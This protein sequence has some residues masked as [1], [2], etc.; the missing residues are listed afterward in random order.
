VRTQYYDGGS[1]PA[2][3][4][5]TG[6]LSAVVDGLGALGD[7]HRSIPDGAVPRGLGWPCDVAKD[8]DTQLCVDGYCCDDLCD[9]TEPRNKCRA[10]NV[11]GI[12]GRCVVALDGTD[13]RGSCAEEAPSTCGQDGT[14]DGRGQCRKWLSGT[15]CSTPS[16]S[17]GSIS[18]ARA[19]DGQGGCAPAAP[20][21]SC[22]PFDCAN[23]SAC[24]IFCS[25]AV[26]CAS[27]AACT[28]GS[29]GAR[30]L[31]QECSGAADCASGHCA[32]GVCCQTACAGT[33]RACDLPGSVGTCAQVPS[34]LDPH[35]DCAATARE[36]CGADGTCDGAGGCRRWIPGT[37]CG[38]PC[39]GGV[40]GGVGYHQCDGAGSCRC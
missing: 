26:G 24:A 12:E 29:C 39:S 5:G 8:C 4:A 37:A 27:G 3:D 40:D 31:G 1:H 14:C 11:P 16:C 13:P 17:A 2:D 22:G 9:P 20:P 10:C 32:E 15:A 35:D 23:T 21:I 7:L 30:A 6:D 36:S 33:C 19:C 38:G 34:G 28:L 25:V 18:Y